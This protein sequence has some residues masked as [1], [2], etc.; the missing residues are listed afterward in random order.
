MRRCVFPDFDKT[1][2]KLSC[3]DDWGSMKN[4][5]VSV[6]KDQ[7]FESMFEV[8]DMWVDSIKEEDYI[9]F[10]HKM[11]S[12]VTMQAIASLPYSEKYGKAWMKRV[13]QKKKSRKPKELTPEEKHENTLKRIV[14]FIYLIFCRKNIKKKLIKILH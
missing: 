12:R 3:L 7:Y 9:D 2:S 14:F 8:A 10:L 1:K 6:D 13:E 4:N 11:Y 5:E